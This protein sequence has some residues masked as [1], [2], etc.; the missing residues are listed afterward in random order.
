MKDKV[1]E[2]RAEITRVIQEQ[3]QKDPSV[4]AEYPQELVGR[5]AAYVREQLVKGRSL[6]QCAQELGLPKAR[7]HYWVYDR[8][9]R[10]REPAPRAVLRP[11]QVSSQMVPVY[12]G[13][14]ER[15]YV[16]RSPSGWELRELTLSEVTELLRRL[17]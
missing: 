16:F 14:R 15:R 10:A 9:R 17:A 12:D 1:E 11:V 2:L 4:L 6:A 5:V 3:A 8:S 7:L 13:V